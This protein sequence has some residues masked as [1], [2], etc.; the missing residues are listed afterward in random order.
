MEIAVDRATL[1]M[2]LFTAYGA[3]IGAAYLTVLCFVVP[4][5]GWIVLLIGLPVPVL[6]AYLGYSISGVDTLSDWRRFLLIPLS[7]FVFPAGMIGIGFVLLFMAFILPFAWVGSLVREGKLRQQMKA[8]GRFLP[9]EELRPKLEAGQGTLIDETGP[10]GPYHIWWTEDDVRAK[11]STAST[12]Q[13]IIAIIQ[14]KEHPFNSQCLEE[15][16]DPDSGRAFLTTIRPRYA[17]SERLARMFPR[18]PVVVR[19]VRPFR[20]GA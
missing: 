13:E 17:R 8:K 16:L 14:G 20:T 10:K 12:T 4:L 3:I 19:M 6:L 1:R 9:L 11:G 2:G 7:P 5:N 15:Y 18:M